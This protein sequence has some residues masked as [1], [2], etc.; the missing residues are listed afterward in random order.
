M[1]ASL[2]NRF[3][4]SVIS[5]GIDAYIKKADKVIV[6]FS[7]GADSSFLLH[8]MKR[9]CNEENVLLEAAHVNHMIRGD[10][11]DRDENFCSDQCRKLGVDI[12]IKK[13]DIPSLCRNGSALEETARKERYSFFE[14]LSKGNVLIATAHNS[15]DNLET[16]LLNISR[17]TSLAGLCGIPTVRD[18]KYIRP[19]LDFSS[20]EIRKACKDLSI[21]FVTDS[22]NLTAD[23]SR[24]FIRMKITPLIKELNPSVCVN[25]RKMCSLLK[26]D[27]DFL[28]SMADCA[29]DDC[30]RVKV[31]K[32]MIL[33]LEKPLLSRVLIQ[34]YEKT[35]KS[36][37]ISGPYLENVHLKDIISLLSVKNVPFTVSVPG[38]LEFVYD[39]SFVYFAAKKSNR[40]EFHPSG[41]EFELKPGKSALFNGYEI[42]C[43]DSESESPFDDCF[44]VKLNSDSING[45]VSVRSRRDG[46]VIRFGS[47]THKVKKLFSDSHMPLSKRNRIPVF[48][49]SDGI[50]WIPSFPP[51]DGTGKH[52][53]DG[54][55]IT[56]Y[57]KEPL[58][59]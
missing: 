7:G 5:L 34:L 32:D 51:R 26:E 17:G 58:E 20:A 12:H 38:S 8:M 43:S 28:N 15:D 22:T 41:T 10:E 48:F 9:Y 49:D 3:R 33:S 19:L 31:R 50:V 30:E 40:N 46:D 23:C 55:F 39:G 59:E 16:V 2:Y 35:K 52:E 21:P 42:F 44:C 37:N 6:A 53:K 57:C 13:V 56:L 47:M 45:T 27:A 25:V 1:K 24:N 14:E 4:C 11:S 18:E 36:L 54:D 29:L